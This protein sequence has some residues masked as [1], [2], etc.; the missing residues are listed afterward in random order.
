M[1]DNAVIMRLASLMAA[2]RSVA[3]VVTLAELVVRLRPA[4]RRKRKAKAVVVKLV[5][6]DRGPAA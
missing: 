3:E 1:S 4:R 5:P 2:S 6:Q